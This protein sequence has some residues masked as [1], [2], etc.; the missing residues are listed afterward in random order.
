MRCVVYCLVVT[1]LGLVTWCTSIQTRAEPVP[2]SA[3]VPLGSP[4]ETDSTGKA[5]GAAQKGVTRV[6]CRPTSFGGTGF[7]HKSG[8][9]ITAAHVVADCAQGDLIILAASGQQTGVASVSA[10]D[11]KDLAILRP[12]SP[13][14]GTPLPI[15]SISAPRLGTQ[16]TTWGYPAGYTG[17]FPLLSVGYFAGV[18]DFDVET[19]ARATR[20]WVVN[21][22][23]NGG[24][25]G[26]PLLAVEDGKVIGVVSSKLA[27]L[28]KDIATILEGLKNERGG[29]HSGWTIK[30]QSVSEAQLVGLVLDYLRK[31]VQLVIG[32]AVTT[33]DLQDFLKGQGIEP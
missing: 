31:Q 26:G 9:V 2:A 30:G 12:T 24:N 7:L 4:V 23:F 3:Q 25:S 28:P 17:I 18:Q 14:S 8:V 6:I 13:L 29:F 27:P 22:A 11:V 33:K 10:D 15:A 20:R 1:V 21:A 32:Y 5:A 19:P 16:V